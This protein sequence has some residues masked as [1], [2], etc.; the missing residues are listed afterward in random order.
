MGRVDKNIMLNQIDTSE[1]LVPF[2][3]SKLKNLTYKCRKIDFMDENK[4][5]KETINDIVINIE[6]KSF[7][8]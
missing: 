8:M 4:S 7:K 3:I 5:I 2:S 1:I 6:K